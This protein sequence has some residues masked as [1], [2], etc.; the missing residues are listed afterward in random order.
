[1]KLYPYIAASLLLAVAANAATYVVAN[2]LGSLYNIPSASF[3]ATGS[4]ANDMAIDSAGNYIVASSSS[5]LFKVTPGGTVTTISTNATGQYT[6]VAIDGSGNFI[7]AD[8][9][10]H[11]VWRITPSGSTANVVAT[12]PVCNAGSLED[13]IVRVNGSG[14][15]V[16]MHDNCGAGIAVY[17]M[18]PGG[19]VT[20]VT[21]SATLP[22]GLGGFTFDASGN[23]VVAD[24][25]NSTISSVTPAGTVSTLATNALLSGQLA[26]IVRDASSG[27]F[28]V[29]NRGTNA[30]LLV[31]PA[32]VVSTIYSSD[33][34]GSPVAV[35][36]FGGSGSPAPPG[37]PVPSALWLTMLGLVTL[38][39]WM[40]RGHR[41]A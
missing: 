34:L 30:L 14:N 18:T 5:T 16:I 10:N 39:A 33:P 37:T 12:Y 41:V 15:Y 21:L 20:P 1:M 3:I 9:F 28:A 38:G 19:T 40:Y 26:G 27:N 32:G 4:G 24:A 7:V 6:S 31:T 23:Y 13:V 36:V 25:G 2:R 22:V 8:N 29:A 35:V 11:E 17:T